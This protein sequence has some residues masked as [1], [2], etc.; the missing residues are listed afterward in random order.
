MSKLQ[1]NSPDIDLWLKLARAEGVG[2][3][4]FGKLLGHFGSVERALGVSASQLTKVEGVGHKTAER[5]AATRD[6]FD[7][8][9][10]LDL[11]EKLGV[12][13]VHSQDRRYPP[14]LRQIY[15]P[16]PVL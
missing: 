6:G 4:T 14:P 7:A 12:W 15:D 16:P 9:A 3:T 1:P 13:L 5:I 10:E 8:V 11:A 2:P